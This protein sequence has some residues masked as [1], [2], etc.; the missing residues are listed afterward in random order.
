MSAFLTPVVT[1]QLATDRYRLVAPLRYE[2]D[3]L[4]CSVT[5]PR[6]FVTDFES[7]PRWLPLTYAWIYGEAHAPGVLHD[8]LYQV[9]KVVFRE[10]TRAEADGLLYEA[11]GASGPGI[12]PI[13]R[14]KRWT[15]W[16]GVRLGG[17][18]AWDSGPSRLTVLWD[19]RAGP[20]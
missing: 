16:S 3:A 7:V 14:L 20:R 5:A 13:G 10:V 12:Q 19:R 9:H 17:Q 18:C 2:S 4:R 15:L 11:A 6:G 1:E 8:Y